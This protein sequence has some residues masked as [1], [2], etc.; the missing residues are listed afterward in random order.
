MITSKGQLNVKL[1]NT[2]ASF[3]L[4]KKVEGSCKQ[5][6]IVPKNACASEQIDIVILIMVYVI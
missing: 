4:H 6:L 3:H 2:V 5:I 1:S